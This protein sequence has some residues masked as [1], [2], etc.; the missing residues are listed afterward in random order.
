MRLHGWP[1]RMAFTNLVLPAIFLTAIFGVALLAAGRS[2][3]NWRA[4]TGELCA[5][6]GS[7]AAVG[8]Q[9]IAARAPLATRKLCWGGGPWGG[10]AP[11]YP[12]LMTVNGPG[13]GRANLAGG[14]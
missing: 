9:P 3:F 10:K 5:G 14:K 6:A 2:Y 7:V 8:G 11:K 12:H 1:V 13:V 4:G